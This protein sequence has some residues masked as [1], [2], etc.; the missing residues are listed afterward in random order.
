MRKRTIKR[1]VY[2]ADPKKSRYNYR[3]KYYNGDNLYGGLPYRKNSS[4]NV[5]KCNA[6]KES[7][8]Y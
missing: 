4:G 3:R 1:I 2:K 5:K 8:R 7:Q 6:D